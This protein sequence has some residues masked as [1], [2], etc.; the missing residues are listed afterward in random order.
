MVRVFVWFS[1]NAR[2]IHQLIMRTVLIF[3]FFKHE[4]I[5]RVEAKLRE[6]TLVITM[7]IGNGAS[8]LTMKQIHK[9]HWNEKVLERKNKVPLILKKLIE[10]HYLEPLDIY[11]ACFL[12][13]YI[14]Y[15]MNDIPQN[16]SSSTNSNN[17]VYPS[18]SHLMLP[19]K[20]QASQIERFLFLSYKVSQLLEKHEQQEYLKNY[21]LKSLS[22][23][24]HNMD[25][26]VFLT[27]W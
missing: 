24:Y 4:C 25:V 23:I 11:L 6:N 12:R 7:K 1:V 27:Y 18:N 17:K 19:W 9:C 20:F 22:G 13:I 2:T 26:S 8:S 21:L 16:P 3:V 15:Y 14:L 10:S 5:F